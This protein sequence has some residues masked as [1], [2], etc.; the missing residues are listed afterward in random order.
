MR[1]PSGDQRASAALVLAFGNWRAAPPLVACSL[2]TVVRLF[3]P[4]SVERT[5]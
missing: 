2:V 4:T 5:E 1:L 3:A